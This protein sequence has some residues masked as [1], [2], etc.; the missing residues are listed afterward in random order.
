[1]HR[2]WDRTPRQSIEAECGRRG[3]PAVVDA[4]VGILDGAPIDDDLLRVL[5]G[6]A[7]ESVIAGAEGGKDGYWP[8]VWALRGLLH[9]WSDE[10]TPALLRATDDPAWRV[11]EMAAKVVGRH[12]V[13]DALDAVVRLREDPRPRVRSAA[14]RAVTA[15]VDRRA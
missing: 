2:V 4:C 1:M 11:R 15:L 7:A 5:A 9:V 3:R 10:A 14:D 6:P 8:R 13:G 12:A